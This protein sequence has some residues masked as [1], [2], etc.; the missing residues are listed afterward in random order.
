MVVKRHFL[1]LLDEEHNEP[2]VLV[3][4]DGDLVE[5]GLKMVVICGRRLASDSDFLKVDAVHLLD[6]FLAHRVFKTVV[7]EVN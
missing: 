4:L 5:V 7:K 3:S 1:A 2:V 6:N